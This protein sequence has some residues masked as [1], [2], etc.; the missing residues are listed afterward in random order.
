LYKKN[1][2]LET[3]SPLFAKQRGAGGEFMKHEGL[4]DEFTKK[5][6]KTRF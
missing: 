2:N 5:R 3:G 4:G 1:K 6:E